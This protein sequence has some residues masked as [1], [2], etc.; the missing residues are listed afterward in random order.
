[1]IMGTSTC[2]LIM[3]ETEQPVLGISG[4]VEDGIVPGLF[5]YEAGQAGVGDIF[6]WFINNGVPYDYQAEANDR[7]ISI[8]ELLSEKA[9]KLMVNQHGLL[10]LDWWN[11]SRTPLV[12]ADLTGVLIGFTLATPP[13]AIYRALIE[14]TAYGT[15][16]IV[17][18]F[19]ENGVP[20][21]GLRA[22]GGLT[23]NPLLMQIYADVIGQPIEITATEQAS[24]LG[25]AILG[26][27]GGGAYRSIEEAVS[28]MTPPAE[29]VIQ[30]NMKNHKV[31]TLFFDEYKRLVDMFGREEN[32]PLK[33]IRELR[34]VSYTHLTLPTNREV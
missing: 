11:G 20:V 19:N 7:G 6:A 17:D 27:V 10:A 5:G 23:K 22:S 24:A 28:K 16:L 9:A 25:A 15:R 30:P 2:H 3:S 18:L 14:S 4:V 1:M 34:P 13:E 8:H 12:D 21:N 31:Y 26:A 29:K 33:R 32:S